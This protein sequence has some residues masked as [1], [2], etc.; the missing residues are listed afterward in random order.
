MVAST[1]VI[2]PSYNRA[3]LLDRAISSVLAQTA[4]DL[5]LIV[6]DDHSTDRTR[7]V[8]ESF[9]D[10]RVRYLRTERRRGA[11]A[12]RNVGIDRASGEFVAF[13]DSDDEWL[14]EK[15]E[16][17]LGAFVAS[18]PRVALVYGARRLD[19]R[20][21]DRHPS[22]DVLEALLVG[23]FI[24]TGQILVRSECLRTVGAFDERL[25]SAQDWDLWIR[26]AERYRFL[27]LDG[28]VCA[29]HLQPDSISHDRDAKVRGYRL[30]AAK[31]RQ[32]IDRL[33][34]KLRAAHYWYVARNLWGVGAAAE[35]A[36]YLLRAA[37]CSPS[38]ICRKTRDCAPFR[39]IWRRSQVQIIPKKD[40]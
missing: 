9:A 5:E 36:R 7:E 31:H 21:T 14:P 29:Y 39:R 12:A 23:N 40:P 1:S 19:D 28:V 3:H 13:V 22:G 8:V 10:E 32:K 11:A 17:Q 30:L 4:P 15:L 38:G 25:P 18:G 35:T 16:R 2:L 33:P 26:L 34:A 6:V 37:I 27:Y 20:G 24:G